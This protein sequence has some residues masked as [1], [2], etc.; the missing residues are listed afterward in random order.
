LGRRAASAALVP[1]D[2]AFTAAAILCGG[3]GRRKGTRL[4]SAFLLLLLFLVALGNA[5]ATALYGM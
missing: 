1:G 3:L 5:L 2:E 4:T